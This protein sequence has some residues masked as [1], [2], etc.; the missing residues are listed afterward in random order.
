MKPFTEF[1]TYVITGMGILSMLLLIVAV[2]FPDDKEER[3]E[4]EKWVREN[5]PEKRRSDQDDN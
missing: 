5:W 4:H 2:C 1:L 3:E